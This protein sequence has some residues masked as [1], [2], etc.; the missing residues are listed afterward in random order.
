MTQRNPHKRCFHGFNFIWFILL[1]F[2]QRRNKA[3]ICLYNSLKPHLLSFIRPSDNEVI[4]DL[5]YG[6]QSLS[7]KKYSKS[8][9]P[10]Y[11]ICQ[12]ELGQ[13]IK[14]IPGITRCSIS[15]IIR[16]IQ[17]KTTMRYHST[18]VRMAITKSLQRI[19]AGEGVEKREPTYTVSGNAN[20]HNRYGEQHAFCFS[21]FHSYL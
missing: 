4:C 20:W 9:E 21:S 17:N 7:R 2:R 8:F 5:W 15:L 13:E 19:N 3:F 14:V 12:S 18:L 11:P 1:H 6:P 10:C 16:E